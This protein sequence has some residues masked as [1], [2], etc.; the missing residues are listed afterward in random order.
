MLSSPAEY[1]ITM[2]LIRSMQIKDH[3]ALCFCQMPNGAY[4]TV[5]TRKL[6][7]PNTD[8]AEKS[9]PSGKN[10]REQW[11]VET[12]L[13]RAPPSNSPNLLDGLLPFTRH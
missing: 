7:Y 4:H 5:H 2:I 1:P 11:E 10:P 13:T 3:I 9:H 6:V 12:T 8:Y